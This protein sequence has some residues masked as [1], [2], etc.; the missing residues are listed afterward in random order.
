MGIKIW[1]NCYI[2]CKQSL[3]KINVG[4]NS[5]VSFR[6]LLQTENKTSHMLCMVVAS[7]NP[8]TREA[9]AGES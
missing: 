7:C 4:K 9:E 3:S 1:N 5:L 2:N 8:S 6:N